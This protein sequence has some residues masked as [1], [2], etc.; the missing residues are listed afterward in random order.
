RRDCMAAVRPTGMYKI[1]LDVLTQC[2]PS[3][4]VETPYVFVERSKGRSKLGMRQVVDYVRQLM[5]LSSWR[6]LKFAL[7]GA[8]GLLVAWGVLYISPLPPVFSVALAI[9]ASLTSN[10]TLNRLW[11]FSKRKTPFVQGWARYHISTA[12]GN[13]ANYLTTLTLHALGVWIYLAYLAGVTAGYVAN[14]T[15]SELIVFTQR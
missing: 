13:V 10:Y 15:L 11:T 1:L 12:V 14:Y 9:E 3:C 7:V 8:T 2:R 5:A 4:V 6:P